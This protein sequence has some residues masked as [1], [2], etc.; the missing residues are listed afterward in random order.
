MSDDTKAAPAPRAETDTSAP[1]PTTIE[2]LARQ[3]PPLPLEA[4]K[5]V[6]I[7]QVE[8]GVHDWLVAFARAQNHWPLG[9]E[10]TRTEFEAAINAAFEIA[11]R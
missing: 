5:A 8:L 2:P 3:P 11:F 10:L 4:R 6:E 9:R 1:V 7:W